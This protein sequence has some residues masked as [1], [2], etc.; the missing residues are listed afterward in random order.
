MPFQYSLLKKKIHATV[1]AYFSG[2]KPLIELQIKY[3][4]IHLPP[5]YL[6]T[7]SLTTSLTD[8]LTHSL[9]IPSLTHSLFFP[10]NA[11]V[12]HLKLVLRLESL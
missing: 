7:H 4:L 6:L 9:P 1:C 2:E 3:K 11:I 12:S 5:I 8:Y 10:H